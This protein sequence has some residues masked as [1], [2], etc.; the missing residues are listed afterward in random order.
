M[1]TLEKRPVKCPKC[2][3]EAFVS[4]DDVLYGLSV[5]CSNGHD[6]HPTDWDRI[7][8]LAAWVKQLA[9]T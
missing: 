8:L 4:D 2:L 5:T 3:E 7:N 1:I 6:F 9:G